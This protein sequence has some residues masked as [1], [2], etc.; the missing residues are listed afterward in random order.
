MMHYATKLKAGT[1]L[2]IPLAMA[3][4]SDRDNKATATP[5]P[6]PPPAASIQSQ[7]GASF[8][9][10]YDAGNTSDPKDPLASDVPPLSLTTEPIAN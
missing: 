8:A 1:A 10:Y 4:C 3:A 7:I 2:L 9:S 6:G 5:P